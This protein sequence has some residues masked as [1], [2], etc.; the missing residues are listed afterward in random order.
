MTKISPQQKAANTRKANKLAAAEVLAAVGD[1]PEIAEEVGTLVQALS[2]AAEAEIPADEAEIPA[3]EAIEV[4]RN[5]SRRNV[6][7]EFGRIRPS[8]FA[9]MTPLQAAPFE[10]LELCVTK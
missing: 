5:T 2:E 7:T 8:Q 10:E 4:Y 9:N 1:V 6:Y 3:D